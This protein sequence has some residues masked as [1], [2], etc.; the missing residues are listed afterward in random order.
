MSK[1]DA[2]LAALGEL[3][4]LIQARV[5]LMRRL[6]EC[7]RESD[8][9]GLD[10]LLREEARSGGSAAFEQRAQEIRRRIAGEAGVAS[11][12]LSLEGLSKRLS[13][14]AAIALNDRR[15]RLRLSLLQLQQEAGATTRLVRHAAGFTNRLLSLLIGAGEG[16]TYAA[17]GTLAVQGRSATFRQTV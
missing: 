4:G 9:E 10:A 14:P 13:G 5:R 2:I 17:D 3:E 15:E 7:V 1:P 16:D 11:H 6:R 12:E 8:L